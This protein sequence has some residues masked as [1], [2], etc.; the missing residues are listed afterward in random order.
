MR[1]KI[2]ALIICTAMQVFQIQT[3]KTIPT[4]VIPPDFFQR[5][6]KEIQ[7][8]QQTRST[9]VELLSTLRTS[10][11]RNN[12]IPKTPYKYTYIRIRFPNNY[13]LQVRTICISICPCNTLR[14]LILIILIHENSLLH[15]FL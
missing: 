5:T 13:I 12:K 11:M 6:A 14:I 15:I 3:D 9:D 10:A 8:E 2:R 1:I 4:P 7:Q